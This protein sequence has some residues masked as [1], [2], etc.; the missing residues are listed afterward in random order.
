MKVILKKI[1]IIVFVI[2]NFIGIMDKGAIV[3]NSSTKIINKFSEKNRLMEIK[4]KGVIT[5]AAPIND[6]P[7]YFTDSETNEITGLEADIINELAN[8]L[9]IKK[10]EIEET[11]FSKLIEK[12]TTDE[13]IDIAAGGMYITPER[14]KLVA[15]TEPLYKESEAVI[16]PKFS[17]INFLNDLK[18]S[19]VGVVNGTV[20]IDLVQKWKKDKLV[21]D[22]A[23]FQNTSELFNAVNSKKVDAGLSDSILV[24]SYMSKDKNLLLRTIKDYTPQ[25]PGIIGIAVRKN[26]ISLVNALNEEIREMKAD[27]ALYTILLKY[28]LDK[29][30]VV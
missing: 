6:I 19:V 16:V 25:L 23:V 9:G 26:D 18:D 29:N 20:Y 1:L 14:E 5:L 12:I 28:G 8:R 24:N 2:V 27:G 30:N 17:N 13:S 11:P 4:K 21:K 7:F 15:F 3:C 10:V 22:I